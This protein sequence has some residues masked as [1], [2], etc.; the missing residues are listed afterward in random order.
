MCWNGKTDNELNRKSDDWGEMIEMVKHKNFQKRQ[1]DE[2]TAEKC[3][4]LI[5]MA[6][7]SEI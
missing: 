4:E 3:V 1:T 2:K 6:I 5:E 7:C